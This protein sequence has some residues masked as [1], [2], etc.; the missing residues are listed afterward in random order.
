LWLRGVCA[1]GQ[2]A[3]ALFLLAL[4]LLEKVASGG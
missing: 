4:A 2:Y 3:V 1:A